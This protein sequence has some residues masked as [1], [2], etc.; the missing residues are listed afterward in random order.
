MCMYMR[1]VEGWSM[2]PLEGLFA[3][4]KS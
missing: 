3:K 4:G 2:I 1:K